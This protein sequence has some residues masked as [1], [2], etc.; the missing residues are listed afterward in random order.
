MALTDPVR[1]LTRKDVPFHFEPKQKA[2]F[3]LLKQSMAEAGTLA[4]FNKSASTKVLLA[5]EL[6]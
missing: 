4:Y 6:C 2:S 1:K 5:L 3:E